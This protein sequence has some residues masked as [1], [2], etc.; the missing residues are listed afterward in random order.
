MLEYLSKRKLIEFGRKSD[1]HKNV[2]KPLHDNYTFKV[3]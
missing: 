1:T 3:K 2:N